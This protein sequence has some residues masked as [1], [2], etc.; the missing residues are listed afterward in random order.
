MLDKAKEFLSSFFKKYLSKKN[1]KKFIGPIVIAIL[2]VLI[3]LSISICYFQF[4]ESTKKADSPDISVSLFDADGK[5][6]DSAT[7]QEDIVDTSPLANIFYK[8]SFS[9]V[10][11]QKPV[12]FNKKQNMSYTITYNSEKSIFKCYFEEDSTLSYLEDQNGNFFSP[13]ALAYSMFLSSAYS[14][15]IYKD[16]APPILYTPLNEKIVPYEVEWSYTLNDESEKASKN[17]K[18]SNDIL[19]YHIAGAINISFSREPDACTVS[20]K[21]LSGDT[22]F[23]GSPEDLATLTVEENTELLVFVN[24]KWEKGPDFTS[25]GYQ[26]YEFKIICSEPSTFGISSTDAVGGQVLVLSVSDVYDI[27]SIFYSPISSLNDET[28]GKSEQDTMAL[29]K[30]Y[31]YS[32]IFV[33]EGS[34]AYALLPIPADIPNTEFTFSISCGISK[35]AITVTLKKSDPDSAVI[36]NALISSAQKAEFSRILFYLKHSKS[37]I[38]L[39]NDKFVFPNNYGFTQTQKYNTHINGSFTLFA[40]SYTAGSKN[41]ISVSSANVGII[42]DV[43]YSPLLG[44]YVIIDHGMGLLTWYCGLSDVSVK[45]SD[46]VKKGDP[47]GRA[48]SSS[49]LC[50]NGVNIICSVGGILVNPAELSNN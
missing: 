12:E 16:S 7:T 13:D 44:N 41:G 40:N 32:P 5:L 22:V 36:D 10:K 15:T 1:A 46:I 6:I 31:S 33:K 18:I 50:E 42:S 8:L 23:F 37:D 35:E 2:T 27:N 48:G 19:T 49:L 34:N 3:P 29:T 43:G 11:A 30:L 21:T 38:L 20:V 26:H 24:A 39:L 25:H 45:E 14:E 17:Y 28:K 47:I 4:V 9:K